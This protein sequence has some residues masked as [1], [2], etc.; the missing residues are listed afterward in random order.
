MAEKTGVTIIGFM[1]SGKMNIYSWPQRISGMKPAP[2]P[3]AV[4]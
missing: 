2:G 4:T 3:S 1:R